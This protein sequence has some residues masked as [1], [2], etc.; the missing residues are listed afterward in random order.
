MSS[1]IPFLI[2]VDIGKHS[3]KVIGVHLRHKPIVKFSS[4]TEIAEDASAGAISEVLKK[5]L[6]EHK[7]ASGEAVLTFS[8]DTLV[9]RRMEL[10]AM[11]HGEIAN[12]LQWKAKDIPSLEGKE[13]AI[14]FEL[15][16]ETSAEYGAKI[17]NLMFAAVS[18]DSVDK[19]VGMLTAAG[20]RVVSI[21]MPP[22]G[23]A[24]I[25]KAD[26]SPEASGTVMIADIG[27][28]KTILSFYRNKL[29]EFVRVIP[30][31][32]KHISEA[33]RKMK[34]PEEAEKLKK[35]IVIP[36]DE[37]APN[38]E[39]SMMLQALSL[40]RPTVEQ[41]SKEIRRSIDYYEQEYSSGGISCAYLAGG[42]SGIKNLDRYLSDE[43][44]IPV[45]NMVLPASI[46]RGEE[47]KDDDT[48]SVISLIGIALGYNSSA[49]LLPV[50]YRM[51]KIEMVE[52]IALRMAG[53]IAALAL[54]VSFVFMQLQVE[55]YKRRLGLL[56]H[57]RK[58]LSEVKGLRDAA[59]ELDSFVA[60]IN[61][62]DL[63]VEAVMKTLSNTIPPEVILSSLRMDKNNTLILSGTARGTKESSEKILAKFME[64]LEKSE[65]FSAADLS[66]LQTASDGQGGE[67]R[68]DMICSLRE[69]R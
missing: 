38:G 46:G 15:L 2:G 43:L 40:I 10:P 35:S 4:V 53:V 51:K 23:L 37:K 63:P 16:K 11:P 64:D 18:K 41:I 61:R 30:V 12:A 54:V 52:K 36:C 49:N 20:M 56:P 58:I 59:T 29:L 6:K 7:I 34:N 50:K 14:G 3:L 13:A 39:D 8:D 17:L 62:L 28:S 55:N 69:M 1:K 42:G 31:G 19:K 67:S 33:L 45:K 48:L 47:F 65:Y 25:L 22:F 66:S 68:F 21:G 24:A 26:E 60:V 32:S 57:E 44:R 9:F 27:F 5:A